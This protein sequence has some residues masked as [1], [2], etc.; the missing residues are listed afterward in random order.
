[1][2]PSG[3]RGYRTKPMP[4][5]ILTPEE[6]HALC[7][8]AIS[9]WNTPYTPKARV[10]GVGVDCGG[11]IYEV[12]NPYIGPF[13]AYPEYTEDFA[14]HSDFERYLDFIKPHSR[15]VAVAQPGDISLFHFGLVYAHAAILLEDGRYI[16]AYGTRRAGRVNIS[17]ARAM[18]SMNKSFG[19]GY[20]VKHFEGVKRG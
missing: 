4:S 18:Y 14:L 5:D 2:T 20:V 17:H 13:A 6:R 9:W 19:N 8:D 15:P 7:Q 10:K 3:G 11:L 12:F 16:H 1:M